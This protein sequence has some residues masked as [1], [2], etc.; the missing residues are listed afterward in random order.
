MRTVVLINSHSRQAAQNVEAV[1]AY[2]SADDCPFE[3]LDF[4]VIGKNLDFDAAMTKLGAYKQAECVIVGSGDGTILAVLN[5]LKGREKLVY[6]FLPLGTSNDFVWSLGLP[7]DFRKTLRSL[8]PEHTRSVPLGSINGTLFANIASIGLP[9]NVVNTVTDKLKRYLG[10]LAYIVRGFSE[11]LHHD[12]VWCEITIDGETTSFYTH[13]LM[14]ANGKY[15]GHF[16]IHE[17]AG[18]AYNHLSIVAVG[19]GPSRIEWL[20]SML[21]YILRKPKKRKKVLAFPVKQARI[22]TR[23]AREIQA[24]GEII[25]K[26]PAN[27][28]LA[29]HAIQV[30]TPQPKPVSGRKRRTA[31]LSKRTART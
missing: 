28:K 31:R 23:P 11:L 14:I 20:R 2:F 15:H 4:L 19:V 27:I 1:R 24:D 9:T 25:G 18:L 30:L 8:D 5:T 10:P 7:A 17:S 26:T 13:F 29:S 12:A 3:L 22:R 6:G 16:E 21:R